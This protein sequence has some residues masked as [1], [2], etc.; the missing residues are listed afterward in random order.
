MSCRARSERARLPNRSARFP[1]KA[2][3]IDIYMTAY[4]YLICDKISH[5]GS[6][7]RADK[8]MKPYCA[9]ECRIGSRQV[10]PSCAGPK[11]LRTGENKS[12]VSP[13]YFFSNSS[14]AELMQN[15]LPVGRG[16]SS[17]TCPRCASHLEQSTSTL[18]ML[19]LVSS[20]SATLCAD[21]GS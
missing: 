21:M 16:P 1:L 7:L 13:Y 18:R 3:Q 17:N 5:V 12:S 9:E 4:K 14:D 20:S 19:W 15:R 6:A 8:V 2:L 10:L 11:R